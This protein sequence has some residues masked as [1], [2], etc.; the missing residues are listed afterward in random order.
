M[1]IRDSSELV[2][3]DKFMSNLFRHLIFGLDYAPSDKFVSVI[4]QGDALG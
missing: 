3:E 4:T 1:C 2:K